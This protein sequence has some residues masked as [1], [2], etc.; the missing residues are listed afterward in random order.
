ML[1]KLVRAFRQVSDYQ[2]L[3]GRYVKQSCFDLAP[4]ETILEIIV[5]DVSRGRLDSEYS[6]VDLFICTLTFGRSLGYTQQISARRSAS[7]A[8]WVELTS[9][10]DICALS[11][12]VCQLSNERRVPIVA[13][14][15]QRGGF[16]LS[17]DANFVA[18]RDKSF[19]MHGKSVNGD[20]GRSKA[21]P[22]GFGWICRD[23]LAETFSITG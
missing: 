16:N 15:L 8:M 19:G 5:D 14:F 11:V 18:G 9:L 17:Y 12:H 21:V 1:D 2:E 7:V 3:A 4:H 23:E 6:Y 10:V 20:A 22:M 13:S